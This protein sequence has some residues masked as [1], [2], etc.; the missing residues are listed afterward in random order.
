MTE[1]ERI[2]RG[3]LTP[4]EVLICLIC[5]ACEKPW[6]IFLKVCRKIIRND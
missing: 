1:Q 5:R 2:E 3:L 6:V 4:K